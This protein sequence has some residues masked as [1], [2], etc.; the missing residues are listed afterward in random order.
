MTNYLLPKYCKFTSF[1]FSSVQKPEIQVSKSKKARQSSS[2]FWILVFRFYTSKFMNILVTGGTGLVGSHLL[3]HLVQHSPHQ[4]YAIKRAQSSL[5]LVKTIQHKIHWINTDLLDVA[6]LAE[7]MRNMQ[8]VYHCAAVISFNPKEV[9]W[10][11][12]VNV[13]GTANVVNLALEMEVQKLVYVSSIAAIGRSEQQRAITE[14]TKWENSPHN[15]QYAISKYLA[16][17][18]VW[19]GIA[20]GLNAVIVNPSIIL[21]EGDWN[22]GSNKLFSKVWNGLRFYTKGATG[23]VDVKDVVQ[24]MV[25]LMESDISSERFILNGSNQSWQYFL[26]TVATVL[27]KPVPNQA[28]STFLS[29]LYWRFEAIKSLFLR[30][31]PLVT[32]ETTRTAQ[33][34]FTYSS[35]KIQQ[36]LGY[37]FLPLEQSIQR[38]GQQFLKDQESG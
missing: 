4:I 12:Q 35:E 15:T 28:A 22:R 37:A 27:E 31:N 30:T 34:S 32:K 13:T 10:M 14:Q 36:T 23:F 26:Q 20:E 11:R 19:R 9:S 6:S 38:I 16:E 21:G 7:A 3:H 2:Y 24:S 33:E 1:V 25:Q 8:Q 29:E 18:E 17:R 5:A